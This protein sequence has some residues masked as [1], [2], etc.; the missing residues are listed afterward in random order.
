[1]TK[2]RG[3]QRASGRTRIKKPA[4]LR[5]N[6]AWQRHFDDPFPFPRRRQL[7]TLEDAGKYITRLP[8]AEHKAAEW[9]AAMEGLILAAA[10]GGATMFTRIGIMRGLNRAHVREYN[11]EAKPRSS[12]KRN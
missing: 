10:E 7:V 8:K 1:M 12:G 5:P 9:Q 6:K 11:K 3:S 4:P 2:S